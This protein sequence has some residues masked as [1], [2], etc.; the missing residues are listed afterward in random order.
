MNEDPIV[1]E[2]RKAGVELFARFN[3]DVH[4]VC[5]YLRQRAVDR[6]SKTVALPP[7]QPMCE[8]AQKKVG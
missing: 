5:E 1:E 8:P 2:T 7:R 4:A 6:G 3:N